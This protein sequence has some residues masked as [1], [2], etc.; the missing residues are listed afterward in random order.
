MNKQELLSTHFL[1]RDMDAAVIERI[2]KLGVT[3]KL[4]ANEVLFLKGDPGD[5]LYGVLSGEI[6]VSISSPD[7]KE[8]ILSILEPGG[9]FGEIALLDGM[10]RT[11][12]ASAMQPTELFKIHRREFIEF[13]G[14]NPSLAAHLLKMV[15]ARVRSSNE[16]VEDYVFLELSERLAKRLLSLCKFH[17]EHET[18]N[19]PVELRISQVEL[20]QLMGTS[21]EAVNRQLQQW[22]KLGWIEMNK[23]RVTIHSLNDLQKFVAAEA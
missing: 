6:K 11:A 2:A 13:L 17:S 14:G 21:R 12:N 20:G 7:G 10:P 8:V 16:F 19:K 15:C 5:A 3:R 22:R 18:D 1:F 23:G 4:A 9:V